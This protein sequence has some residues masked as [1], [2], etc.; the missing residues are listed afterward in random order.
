MTF[1]TLFTHKQ[2]VLM[3]QIF[4][5]ICIKT[6]SLNAI[7]YCNCL[8]IADKIQVKIDHKHIRS[9]QTRQGVGG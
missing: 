6:V 9:D 3:Y 7:A 4:S 2:E 1:I 8:Y 5:E